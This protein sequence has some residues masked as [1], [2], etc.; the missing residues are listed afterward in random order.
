[1]IR[2]SRYI[3]RKLN[4]VFK[5]DSK[6]SDNQRLIPTDDQNIKSRPL[7]PVDDK[8]AK[9]KLARKGHV[10]MYV[11]EE[12]KRY[13]VPVKFLSTELFASLIRLDQEDPDGKIEGPIKIS[14][15][16]VIFERLLKLADM[17]IK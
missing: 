10:A 14:C 16:T 11:G 13:E 5:R 3:S 17:H 6:T 2:L 1:M 8:N 9:P 12:A 7:L 4:S 15:S